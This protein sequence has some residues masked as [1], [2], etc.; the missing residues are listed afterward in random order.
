MEIGQIAISVSKLE[1]AIA[2]Y[3]QQLDLTLLFK[4]PPGLAFF[5]CG[6]IRLMLDSSSKKHAGQGAVIYFKMENIEAWYANKSTSGVVFERVPHLIA[7]MPDHE[8]WM[9]FLKDPDGNLI[10]IM[11]ERYD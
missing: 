9:C 10:G 2:F 8:L 1:R 3:E 7:K 5:K 6:E 11:E 4:T